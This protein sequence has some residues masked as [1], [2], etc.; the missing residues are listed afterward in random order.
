MEGN[1][2]ATQERVRD[3]AADLRAE[4]GGGAPRLL[5]EHQVGGK[6]GDATHLLG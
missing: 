5:P 2:A 3:E 4:G 6:G 1:F